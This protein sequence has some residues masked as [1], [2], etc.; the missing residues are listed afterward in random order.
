MEQE[1][2]STVISEQSTV[3]TAPSTVH[4]SQST[5]LVTLLS[6]LLLLSC[7]IAGFFAY[8]T[9]KLVKE[10][11][12]YNVQVEPTPEAITTPDPTA[13]WKIYINEKY[14]FSFK[15]PTEFK[16]LDDNSAFEQNGYTGVL[17]LQNFPITKTPNYG[18]EAT[19]Q[20]LIYVK[21]NDGETA[22]TVG[23]YIKKDYI[24]L[25]ENSLNKTGDNNVF[26]QIL[27]TFKFTG[28]EPVSCTKEVKLCPDGSTV[29]R[30]GPNCEFAPCPTPKP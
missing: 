19:F 2:Q 16:Y 20:M 27:S 5:F 28:S 6:I 13:D 18:D 3:P 17:S 30:T 4:R 23:V 14:G 29:S 22:K 15:Y 7:I 8:Q 26:D 25:I 21:K 10:L 11:T 12:T 9:Q 1:K 24:F